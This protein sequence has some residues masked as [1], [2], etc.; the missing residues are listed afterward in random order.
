MEAKPQLKQLPA[1][2]WNQ[3]F[4][5]VKSFVRRNSRTMIENPE[6]EIG[7]NLLYDG[8]KVKASEV[9]RGSEAEIIFPPTPMGQLLLG[10][11][12]THDGE[13]DLSEFDRVESQKE[14]EKTGLPH[15]CFVFGQDSMGEGYTYTYEIFYPESYPEAWELE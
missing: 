12:H 7:F 14:A 3:V 4:A 5:L 9:V 8:K 10:T 13:A 15:I 11:F 6:Y 2:V 1:K